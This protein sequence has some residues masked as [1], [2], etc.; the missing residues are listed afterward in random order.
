MWCIIL[1][2]NKIIKNNK[3]IN[4]KLNCNFVLLYNYF[5]MHYN[6]YQYKNDINNFK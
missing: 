5:F 4:K 1:I 3:I 6:I 2:I